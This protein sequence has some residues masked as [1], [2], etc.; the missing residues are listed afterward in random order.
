M[1]AEVELVVTTGP[2]MGRRFVFPGQATVSVGRARDCVVCLGGETTDLTVSR[3][4]C[5][6]QIDLQDVRVRDLGSRN[7]T[8]VNGRWLAGG[9]PCGEAPA[10]LPLA[11]G[12]VLRVGETSFRVSVRHEAAAEPSAAEDWGAGPIAD[13]ARGEWSEAAA[14]CAGSATP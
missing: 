7:G 5:Q 8:R 6:L 14:C 13:C 4:H 2:L 3:Y 1:V 10:E 12:D 11:E 9:G